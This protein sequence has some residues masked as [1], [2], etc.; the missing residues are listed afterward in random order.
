MNIDTEFINFESKDNTLQGGYEPVNNSDQAFK[1]PVYRSKTP[2]NLDDVRKSQL[3]RQLNF[4]IDESNPIRSGEN[5]Y[6]EQQKH[7]SE[8]TEIEQLQR[9]VEDLADID[10]NLPPKTVI[11]HEYE[12]C[13]FSNQGDA[14]MSVQSTLND[15]D[16]QVVNDSSASSV[17]GSDSDSS[18]EH[19]GSNSGEYYVSREGDTALLDDGDFS[20][21]KSLSIIDEAGESNRASANSFFG[22]HHEERRSSSNNNNQRYQEFVQREDPKPVEELAPPVPTSP[23]PESSVIP[24][25]SLSSLIYN[26]PQYGTSTETLKPDDDSV[27]LRNEEDSLYYMTQK[28]VTKPIIRQAERVSKKDSVVPQFT[29]NPVSQDHAFYTGH[30]GSQIR[31]PLEKVV[32]KQEVY[33][34]SSS[35]KSNVVPVEKYML[36]RKASKAPQIPAKKSGG[37][38]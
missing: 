19:G 35:E 10:K 26:S 13:H 17:N 30:S 4:D 24:E 11:N 16:V 6:N 22:D 36:A 37:N 28:N 5:N 33:R 2:T 27:V 12:V 7:R 15:T 8:N 3:E 38:T 31:R 9:D 20:D 29:N 34:L 21:T 25:N 1:T 18:N 14:A 32:S 23:I